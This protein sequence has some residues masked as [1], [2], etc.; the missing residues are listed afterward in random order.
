MK[1]LLMV[2]VIVGGLFMFMQNSSAENLMSYE[3]LQAKIN[4]QES[5]VL[6]D[7]RTLD[8]YNS[9]HIPTAVLLPHDEISSKAE[10]LVNDKSKEIV[11]YCRSGRRSALAAEALTK[12]GYTNVQDFGGISRWQGALEK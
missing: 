12:L 4:A 6:L 2:A 3:K 5:F 1:Y 8:E 9:G 11:V 7:V 10:T